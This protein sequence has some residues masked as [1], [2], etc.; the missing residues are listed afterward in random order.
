MTPIFPTEVSTTGGGSAPGA[1]TRRRRRRS[2]HN[3]RAGG[4]VDRAP[5]GSADGGWNAQL[6]WVALPSGWELSERLE[7]GEIAKWHVVNAIATLLVGN[8]PALAELIRQAPRARREL[9]ETLS[10]HA[11]ASERVRGRGILPGRHEQE[12]R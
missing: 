11:H 7:N 9:P 4:G 1:N 10:G 5:R 6:H 2:C 8:E 3:C 12:L